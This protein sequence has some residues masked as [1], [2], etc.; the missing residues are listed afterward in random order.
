MKLKPATVTDRGLRWVSLTVVLWLAVAAGPA[1]A[2]TPRREAE[3]PA[4][5]GPRVPPPSDL[6]RDRPLVAGFLVLAASP[7]SPTVTIGTLMSITLAFALVIDF[8]LLPPLLL[9]LA[10]DA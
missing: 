2:H 7:F 8:L 4:N 6:P 5:P 10:R 3:P 1:G 9:A